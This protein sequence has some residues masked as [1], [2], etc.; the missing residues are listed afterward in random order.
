MNLFWRTLAWMSGLLTLVVIVWVSTFQ[1]LASSSWMATG[2]SSPK[3]QLA[4]LLLALAL[5][6]AITA[7]GLVWVTR[8]INHPMDELSWAATRMGEGS[9]E[10]VLNEDSATREVRQVNQGFNRMARELA[11]IEADRAIMLAGISHDL[12]TPLSRLRLEIELSVHGEEARQHMIQDIDQLDRIINKF[13]DYA[14]PLPDTLQAVALDQVLDTVMNRWSDHEHLNLSMDRPEPAWVWADET[15]LCRIIDNLLENAVRYGRSP[16]AA[17]ARVQLTVVPSRRH[18]ALV[19]RDHGPGVP[20]DQLHQLS[21]PFFR[22]D[23]ARAGTPAAGLGL[24]IVDKAL[25]RMGG[26]LELSNAAS[27]GLTA[28]VIVRRAL[29][30]DDSASATVQ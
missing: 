13:M 18:L 27:G 25:Q 28:R 2:R 3:L 5:A 26:R 22:A 15:E 14:R 19:L 8:R 4:I 11:R 24:A 9:Y 16:D 23:P 10:S 29:N 21:K 30:P 7:L 20:P 1:L 6:L 12:R 17:Q